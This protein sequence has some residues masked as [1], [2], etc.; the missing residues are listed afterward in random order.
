MTLADGVRL[1]CDSFLMKGEQV[2]QRARWA[3][4]PA[5]QLPDDT[6]PPPAPAPSATPP[7]ELSGAAPLHP[8]PL[9]GI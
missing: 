6:P 3:G 5:R 8:A 1:A 7:A 2:P 4:N 9:G